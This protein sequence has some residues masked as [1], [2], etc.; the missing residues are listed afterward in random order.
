MT[1][2][3]FKLRIM[4]LHKKLYACA[5]AVLKNESD[6]ADCIQEAFTKLWENR[7]KL[8]GMEN[9]A[10]YAAAA[11]RNIALNMVTRRNPSFT[12][13][14]E[15]MP[16]IPDPSPP[17]SYA[18]ENADE[19]RMVRSLFASLSDSQKRVMELSALAGLSNSEISEAT[20]FSDENV[21]VLI[22]RAR[23][24]IKNLFSSNKI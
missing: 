1:E 9:V 10:G 12:Q 15:E 4:P 5:F 20:G 19:L 21:R 7:R 8:K 11:V 16:D 3:E 14:Q 13:G 23:K 18:V 6:A 2:T 17:P 22:S 24:K